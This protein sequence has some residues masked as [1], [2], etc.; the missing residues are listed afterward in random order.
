MYGGRS[1]IGSGV[2]GIAVR[3]N[4]RVCHASP[5]S[6]EHVAIERGVVMQS[7]LEV[8]EL[9]GIFAFLWVTA[10]GYTRG[11]L[12]VSILRSLLVAVF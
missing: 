4:K 6:F 8:A 3:L 9:C 12:V 7:S 5:L 1:K 2:I 11:S 10:F